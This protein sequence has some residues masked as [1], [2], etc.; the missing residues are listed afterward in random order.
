ML[1]LC[2]A[3]FA[4]LTAHAA[5]KPA[6]ALTVTTTRAAVEQWPAVVQASGEIA[7]WQ[8]AIVAAQVG[9][10]QLVNL[11]V[12][13]GDTVAAGQVLA[14]FDAQT[15]RTEVAELR[16][17]VAQAQASLAQAQADRERADQLREK[18]ALSA[19]DILKYLTQADIAKAQL[20]SARARLQAR[21]LQLKY[22][23]VVAPD[24]GVIIGRQAKL[25]AV[26]PLGEE[27]FRMIRQG[28]L[29]WRGELTAEQLA[30]VAP[31]QQVELL[32]PDGGQAKATIRQIAPAMQSGSRLALVYADI[33]G[34]S[35]ARAGMYAEGTILQAATRALVIPAVSVVIRDGRSIVFL[36]TARDGVIVVSAREV[37][38][39]RRMASQIE[40]LR[41]IAANEE[42]VADGAGFL[43]D[44]DVVRVNNAAVSLSTAD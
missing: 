5:D 24:D 15:L 16:A 26:P 18:G 19:Q 39:G 23:D 43:N 14:Q 22:T 12:E 31:G 36:A 38:V 4:A 30:D 40:I 21:E 25:G 33:A 9:G 3:A 20:A 6:A 17:A 2:V 1:A 11:L 28:R 34:G 27:L 29:E 42:V 37:R 13:V 10:Q 7:A 35:R 32:L 8:E 41:G 44:G